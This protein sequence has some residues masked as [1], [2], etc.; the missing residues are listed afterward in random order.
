MRRK[1]SLLCVVFCGALLT[2]VLPA[3]AL[4]V[5]DTECTGD[6][7]PWQNINALDPN[8]QYC[9]PSS[10]QCQ[11]TD[12]PVSL[13]SP[14]T[15]G[16]VFGNVPENCDNC[17]GMPC[18]ICIQEPP[19]PQY[20][21]Q[22]LS[23]SYT[24]TVTTQLALTIGAGNDILNA[25]LQGS[26]GHAT[27]RTLTY[28]QNC[29]SQSFPGCKIGQYNVAINTMTGIKT[30]ITSSYSWAL[31][32]ATNSNPNTVC[33]EAGQT[34]SYDCSNT[35]DSTATGSSWISGSCQTVYVKWCQ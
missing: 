33:A 11:R 16:T 21:V 22:S 2:S 20:C 32:Y 35:Q 3:R 6:S 31:T 8:A 19:P 18:I 9:L 7:C 17:A 14:G 23:V 26:I 29:G 24:E 1:L 27:Q 4:N 5:A 34:V 13:V 10:E 25:A 12:G 28:T 15:P 30:K